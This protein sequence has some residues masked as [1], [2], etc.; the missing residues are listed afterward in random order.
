MLA[1]ASI[2][3]FISGASNIFLIALINSALSDRSS[4]NIRVVLWYAAICLIV[5]I[6]SVASQVMLIRLGQ[7]TVF[8]LRMLLSS[9]ILKVPLRELERLG[10]H[11]LLG[12]LTQDVA[13]LTDFG[14]QIPLL[15]M[16]LAI[17]L[18]CLLYV[19]Y[20]S[21][22][23]AL[24]VTGLILFA[25]LTYRI[26]VNKANQYIAKAR[27]QHDVIMKHFTA[28]TSGLKEL[29]LHADRRRGFM[30]DMR[31]IA[32]SMR[33]NIV[34]G[35][36]LYTSGASWGQS[37]YFF[38]IGGVVLGVPLF[39]HGSA[40]KA[41]TGTAL[42]LIYMRGYL[43]ALVALLPFIDRAQI[44]LQKLDTL[45]VS[46]AQHVDS[47]GISA[48]TSGQTN[49]RLELKN[50]RYHYQSADDSSDF[51]LG[52]IDLT[53]RAGEIIFI[54]GGN[55]SGKTTLAKLITGLYEP[56][57]GEVLLDGKPMSADREHY[58]QHF[59]AVFSDFF[60]FEKLYREKTPESVAQANS[61]LARLRLD[62]KVKIENDSFSTI[63]LSQ[64]QRK[65]LA[66]LSVLL[67]DR[68]ICLFD[69]WAADQDA[70]FREIFYKQ[71]LL[72]LQASGKM[73]IVIS[74]DERYYNL[75][76][77]LIYLENG[78]AIEKGG[79]PSKLAQP[80]VFDGD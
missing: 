76:S 54:T 35:M 66:L 26:P 38:I 3:G 23:I 37:V 41:L 77:R 29:K 9:Q 16:S 71:I 8:E 56:D 72:D 42:V 5:M 69:E 25:L 44:S 58:R 73:V 17:V 6:T 60:L 14:A 28:M 55:G 1:L 75:A 45:G 70:F 30:L 51:V 34:I 13:V 49:V 39:T 43:E 79:K 10:G 65:R 40:T 80:A 32:E 64:G 46:L 31:Q 2:A 53:L 15:S 68:P 62:H 11:R 59:S 57:T 47:E 7:K 63:E 61:Y 21:W 12:S 19:C 74:H 67:E 36:S 52:P 78:Q 33:R 24:L 50:I 48:L 4:I 22:T 27:D 20:L 18:G